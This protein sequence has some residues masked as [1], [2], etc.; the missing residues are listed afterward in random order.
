MTTLSDP[1]HVEH[2][3]QE[4]PM[5]RC[6]FTIGMKK[7]E[8]PA[9]AFGL[10]P[11][12][13][14]ES[15]NIRSVD[16]RGL[17]EIYKRVSQESF[18]KLENSVRYQEAFNRSIQDSLRRI[19][20]EVE[21]VL[22]VIEYDSEKQ[23]PNTNQTEFLY[24]LA[25]DFP[26]N[27]ILVPPILRDI[28][29]L[30]YLQFLESF[31]KIVETHKKKTIFGLIP[32]GSWRDIR[33]VVDF[34]IK[35]GVYFFV[36]DLKGRHP[37]LI[38]QSIALV[39][40]RI[41]TIGKEYGYNGYLHGLNVGLGRKSKTKEIIPAKDILAFYYGFDSFGSSHVSPKLKPNMYPAL[42]D[43]SKPIRLFNR[44]D[45]GYYDIGH[46]SGVDF[47]V[48]DEATLNINHVRVA[49][50]YERKRVFQRIF[51]AERHG[52]EART[53]RQKLLE[54]ATGKHLESKVQ[55]RQEIESIKKFAIDQR[56][57]KGIQHLENW[58]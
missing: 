38:R 50:G 6:T 36:M 46:V 27:N 14:C 28:E 11:N 32:Y 8:T 23:I 58:L 54:N 26:Q 51:N 15:F 49:T 39:L 55:A 31:F 12:D 43:K 34:Y 53:I 18:A 19:P 3:D 37:F 30:S 33:D 17:N 56:S 7:L 1:I 25:D 10:A 24:A 9:R 16:A 5:R 44:T 52:F 41:R 35:K 47:S 20:R 22:Q 45:Y 57:G 29:P 40:D 48:E 21:F 13:E 2:E 42:K 4:F